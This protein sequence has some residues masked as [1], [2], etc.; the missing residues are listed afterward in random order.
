V[1]E[2]SATGFQEDENRVFVRKGY[3]KAGKFLEVAVEADGG[4]K[5]TIWLPEGR[6]GW[7]WR[8]FVNEMK[9]MLEFQGGQIRS[10]VDEYPSLPG[11]WV[12]AEESVS[13]GSR[14]G[15]SFVNVLRLTVGGLKRLS[16]CLLDVFPV[17][18]CFEAELGG[19]EPRSAVNCY[20]MEAKQILSKELLVVPSP[21]SLSQA[22]EDSLK[23][24]EWVQLQV[25]LI[26]KEVDQALG[27]L[28]AGLELKPNGS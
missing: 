8:R 12:E 17:L 10:I 3:N 24:M 9:R 15:C 1:K 23:T 13:S 19:V 7:D 20:A 6:K 25:G 21:A 16:S 14:Y 27:G 5:G 26:C 4:R 22:A 2:G 11:K 18:E 28:I